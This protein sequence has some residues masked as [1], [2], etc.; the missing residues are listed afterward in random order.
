MEAGVL[1]RSLDSVDPF[2]NDDGRPIFP[3]EAMRLLADIPDVEDALLAVAADEEQPLAR[4]FA[5]VE[6]LFQGGWTSWR[7]GPQAPV[8]ARVMADA[9]RADAIHN[10]WGLPGHYVD[11]S[12]KDLLSIEAGVEDALT[13][14]LDDDRPLSIDGSEAATIAHDESPTIADLARYLLAQR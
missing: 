11:R 4:R 5:A 8:L 6:A 10:R 12:G 9:I 14:L 7:S 3:P 2:W 13:P 1:V